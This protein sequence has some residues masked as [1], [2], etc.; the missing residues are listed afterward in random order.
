MLTSAVEVAATAAATVAAT[1]AVAA[2]AEG[3]ATAASTAAATVAAT[4]AVAATAEGAATAAT[5]A[6]PAATTANS[7]C[8]SPVISPMETR[9]R[10][11]RMAGSQVNSAEFQQLDGTN[12]FSS[13]FP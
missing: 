10:K 6:T 12:L 11:N 9:A 2:T 3:A 5:T 4:G 8:R 13:S 7:F 1:G